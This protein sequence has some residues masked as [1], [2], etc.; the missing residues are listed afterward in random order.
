MS[1]KWDVKP[2][3]LKISTKHLTRS[4]GRLSGRTIEHQKFQ[5]LFLKWAS[6]KLMDY[7]YKCFSTLALCQI[8]LSK[9]KNY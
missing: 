2:Q 7:S 9:Q 1:L 6:N 3:K 8:K 4:K 5:V